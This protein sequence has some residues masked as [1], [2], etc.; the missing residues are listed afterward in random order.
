MVFLCSLNENKNVG[1]LKQEIYA[2]RTFYNVFL[3]Y[4][5]DK[6]MYDPFPGYSK[7]VYYINIILLH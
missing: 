7:H 2:G 1:K 3:F 4:K 5:P 6:N